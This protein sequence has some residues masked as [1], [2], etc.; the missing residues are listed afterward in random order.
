MAHQI[1]L[2]QYTDKQQQL[3]RIAK[4]LGH[5]A[6]IAILELLEQQCTC[7]H[8]NLTADLPIAASSVSQHLN[9]LKDAGL[10]QGEFN[11][12]KVKYCINREKWAEAKTLFDAFFST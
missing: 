2:S 12:P 8:G 11:P 7:Y 4:A 9:A 10:I 1:D 6:R 5:P 3:A